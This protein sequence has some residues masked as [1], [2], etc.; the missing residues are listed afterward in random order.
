MYQ[1]NEQQAAE[2]KLRCEAIRE[3]A[4]PAVFARIE[5]IA[6]QAEAS[7]QLADEE[8]NLLYE[9]LDRVAVDSQPEREEV[10]DEWEDAPKKKAEDTSEA[11]RER[12]IRNHI[13]LCN[14]V[15]PQAVKAMRRC[16]RRIALPAKGKGLSR[17]HT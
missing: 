9:L 11:Q 8:V 14:R 1:V 6:R 17:E 5:A 15:N 13:L 10:C 3:C 4:E 7:G 2:L 12:D 16:V